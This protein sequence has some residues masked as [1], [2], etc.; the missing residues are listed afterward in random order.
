M[1]GRLQTAGPKTRPHFSQQAAHI[2][3]QASTFEV[4]AYAFY[5]LERCNSLRGDCNDRLSWT[6]SKARRDSANLFLPSTISARTSVDFVHHTCSSRLP[7]SGCCHRHQAMRDMGNGREPL[8][9]RRKSKMSQA[10]SETS[11]AHPCPLGLLHGFRSIMY[12]ICERDSTDGPEHV[13]EHSTCRE[14]EVSISS[15]S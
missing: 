15:M 8:L 9:Q 12:G 10:C 3:Q 2:S 1:L 14:N 5:G 11:M 13:L 6:G 7:V 4:K